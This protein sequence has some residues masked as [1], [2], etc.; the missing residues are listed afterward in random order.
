MNDLSTTIDPAVDQPPP[1]RVRDLIADA[2]TA[3]PAG[4]PDPLVLQGI[5]LSFGGVTALSGVDLTVA[6][7]E[8]RA[9]IGPNGA[10][11]SSIV[12]VICGVYR[13][14]R[15]KVWIGGHE[16]STVPTDDLAK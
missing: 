2:N 10:G 6:A 11:K 9:I 1:D 5:T 14:D 7:G 3:K 8:I 12:N 4:V 15:G 13:P 16:F